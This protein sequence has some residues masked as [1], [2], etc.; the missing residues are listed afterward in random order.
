MCN[1]EGFSVTRGLLFPQP[2]FKMS[3]QQNQLLNVTEREFQIF[4]Q[5]YRL[6]DVSTALKYVIGRETVTSASIAVNL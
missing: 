2:I 5:N 3:A 4:L 1:Y 6:D